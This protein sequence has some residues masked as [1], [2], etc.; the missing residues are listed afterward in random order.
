MIKNLKMSTSI[1]I[2][3]GVISL[4][5]MIVFYCVL[6]GRVTNVVSEKSTKRRRKHTKWSSSLTS[7]S[8]RTSRPLRISTKL[9]PNSEDERCAAKIFNIKTGQLAVMIM[10]G[11]LIIMIL[12]FRLRIIKKV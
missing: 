1:S 7:S 6:S 4:V 11:C 12:K 3:V 5:C 2:C 9:S 10:A 8:V